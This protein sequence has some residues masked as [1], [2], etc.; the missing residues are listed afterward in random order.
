MNNKKTLGNIIWEKEKIKTELNLVLHIFT[1]KGTI[2][3]KLKINKKPEDI[4]VL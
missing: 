3:V 1:S 2:K 4:Y